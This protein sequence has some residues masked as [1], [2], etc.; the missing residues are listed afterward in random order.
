MTTK[1]RD[2]VTSEMDIGDKVIDIE[3]YVMSYTDRAYGQDADGNR[4]IS[5]TFVED[6][7]DITAYD[8]DGEE[9][10]LTARQKERAAIIL[11]DK[12]FE[13]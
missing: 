5:R 7:V 9:I 3:G 1:E 11:T 13:G 12:F 6:V 10:E 2:L 4:A 8:E